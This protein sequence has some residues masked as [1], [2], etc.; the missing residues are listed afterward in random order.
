M[1]SVAPATVQKT[2]CEGNVVPLLIAHERFNKEDCLHDLLTLFF[3]AT[4]SSL[5]RILIM[6]ILLFTVPE[7]SCLLTHCT[8]LQQ[9][10]NL[11][12][13][14]LMIRILD[15]CENMNT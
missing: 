13:T 7:F 14:M 10:T 5:N 2:T 6:K 11:L 8:L 1:D 4:V 15:S 12:H 3:K 9:N